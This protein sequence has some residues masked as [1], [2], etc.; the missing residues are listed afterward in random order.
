MPKLLNPDKNKTCKKCGLIGSPTLFEK[1]RRV[2]KNCFAKYN[3]QYYKNNLDTYKTKY[4]TPTGNKRGR[5]KKIKNDN[6]DV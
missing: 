1:N 4:Y 3:N 2:C 6:N 5:P